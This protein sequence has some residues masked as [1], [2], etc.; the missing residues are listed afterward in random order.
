MVQCHRRPWSGQKTQAAGAPQAVQM[1]KVR[2]L[3][4][5]K[6]SRGVAVAGWGGEDTPL[7]NSV[8]DL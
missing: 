4:R 3:E 6:H 2:P 8:Q 5:R 7:G 1:A